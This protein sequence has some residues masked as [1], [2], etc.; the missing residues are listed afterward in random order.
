MCTNCGCKCPELGNAEPP[1]YSE[2]QGEI[3]RS[4]YEEPPFGMWARDIHILQRY[5]A[6]KLARAYGLEAMLPIEDTPTENEK[7]SVNLAF[8]E[9]GR[10]VS[11]EVMNTKSRTNLKSYV[12]SVIVAP[13]RS[14]RIELG[15]IDTGYSVW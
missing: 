1:S 3:A 4:T 8:R 6:W 9:W 2:S 7:F 5:L 13:A 10:L 11:G 14:L 15:K 12:I